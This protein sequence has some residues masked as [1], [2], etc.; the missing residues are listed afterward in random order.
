VARIELE[1]ARAQNEDGFDMAR[2]KHDTS[3][4]GVTIVGSLR[5]QILGGT[6]VVFAVLIG[7][8]T[9]NELTSGM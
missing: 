2:R 8:L 1:H 4:Y 9:I 3:N 7:L 6:M 5:M